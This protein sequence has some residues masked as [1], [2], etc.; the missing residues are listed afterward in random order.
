MLCRF[1]HGGAH[2]QGTGAA[3]IYAHHTG[4]RLAKRERVIVVLL[5][6]RLGSFGFL[7]VD[8][9]E[10]NCGLHDVIMALRF[11]KNEIAAFGGD[12]NRVTLAG[13]SA[14]AMMTG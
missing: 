13:E 14:G 10:Y 12:P 5:N 3:T 11:V 6:Y 4:S 1:A 8:G 9:G 2:V 7:K